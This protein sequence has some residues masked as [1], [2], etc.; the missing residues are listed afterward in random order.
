[1]PEPELAPPLDRCLTPRELAR[2]WRT[3]PARVR[4]LIRRGVLRA[5][6]LGRRVRIP[7]EAVA[8][9]G[10]LLAAPVT[11]GRRKRADTGIDR[12]VAALLET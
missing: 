8:E 3:S 9:G 12:D 11:G 5:F 4:Q 10:R 7:P 2:R 6:V 1:M